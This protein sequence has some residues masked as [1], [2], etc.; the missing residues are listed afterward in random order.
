[1]WEVITA[2]TPASDAAANGTS[3]RAARVPASTSTTGSA[4]WLS[5]SVSPW[6]GKCLAHAA[7]PASWTPIS[8]AAACA[9]TRPGPGPKLRVPMTGLSALRVDVGHRPQDEGDAERGELGADGVA[10]SPG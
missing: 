10:R 9:A 7:T 4:R 5:W 6:P 3:S 8:H 2:A 1:M